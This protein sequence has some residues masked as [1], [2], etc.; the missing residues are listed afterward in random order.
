MRGE[1]ESYETSS[2]QGRISKSEC[3]METPVPQ[4]VARSRKHEP[5]EVPGRGVGYLDAEDGSGVGDVHPFAGAQI[6]GA[7]QRISGRPGGPK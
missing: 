5:I 2:A 4:G 1:D 6:G 7:L 3:R